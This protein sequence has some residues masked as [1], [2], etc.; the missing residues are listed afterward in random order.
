[1][2]Q[3]LP[4]AGWYLDPAGQSDGRYWDGAVWTNAVARSGITLTVPVDPTV[5]AVPPLPGTAIRP[6]AN[7]A[8]TAATN[9]RSPVIIGIGV[10]VAALFAVLLIAIVSNDDSPDETPPPATEAPATNPP[11]DDPPPSD[12]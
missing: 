9:D 2:N 5:S 7:T 6:P 8:T 3:N 4:P 11:A 1:M 10:M 12:N